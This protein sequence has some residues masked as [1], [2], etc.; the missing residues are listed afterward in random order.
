MS[1]V[2]TRVAT[3]RALRPTRCQEES[4]PETEGEWS[5]PAKASPP[6][7]QAN[8]RA[9]SV[10]NF[11]RRPWSQTMVVEVIERVVRQ[12]DAEERDDHEGTR[13]GMLARATPTSDG[14]RRAKY[15][16]RMPNRNGC[17]LGHGDNDPKPWMQRRFCVRL[18]DAGGAPERRPLAPPRS[19]HRENRRMTVQGKT[20]LPGTQVWRR[21]KALSHL[22]CCST[23]PTARPPPHLRDRVVVSAAPHGA[24]SLKP[25]GN[26]LDR[27]GVGEPVLGVSDRGSG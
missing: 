19:L 4:A 27:V 26:D 8:L 16:R 6:R 14:R 1:V 17:Q 9:F 18:G 20:T 10:G 13:S 24:R 11:G 23:E 7:R 2:P 25:T 3:P 22:T 15:G 21:K 5:R 12:N